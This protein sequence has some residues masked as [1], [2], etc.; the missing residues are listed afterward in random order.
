MAGMT[1]EEVVEQVGVKLAQNERVAPGPISRPM[2]SSPIQRLSAPPQRAAAAVAPTGGQA[3]ATRK[4]CL[5]CQ[6][7]V[8]PESRHPLSCSHIIHRDC[9]RV[10]L[11]ASKNNSCPFCPTK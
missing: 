3:A 9:I 6:K 8:D 7:H 2:S 1:M 5:M 10:W 11:Q 4:L